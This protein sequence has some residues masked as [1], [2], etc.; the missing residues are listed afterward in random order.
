MRKI[1]TDND[2][3]DET[4]S[5]AT[6]HI[7]IIEAIRLITKVKM[8]CIQHGLEIWQSVANI[9]DELKACMVQDKCSYKQTVL[10]SYFNKK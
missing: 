1:V 2:S 6:E 3:D 5:E 8:F 7:S 4:V 9:E 10:T